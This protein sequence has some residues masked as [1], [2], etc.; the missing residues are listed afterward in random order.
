MGCEELSQAL[1]KL[2]LRDLESVHWNLSSAQLYEAAIRRREG[3][4]AYGGALVTRTGSFTGRAPNDKFIVDEPGSRDKIWW[5]K[6]NRPFAEDRFDA[7]YRKACHFL[8]GETVFVQDC[9][10]NA[11]PAYETSV[12]VITQ[13]AW[14]SLF[15]RNLFIRPEDLNRAVEPGESRITVLHVPHLH[16]DPIRDGTN[17]EAF[18]L[19][20]FSRSLVLIGGTQYAG[21]IK[22]SVFSMMNYLLPQQGILSM[23]AAAN[24]G[25]NGD[26]T[27]FFG[28]SGT[29]KTTLSA[30]P[31]RQ[32][33]GDDETG[34]GENGLFN[35]EGGCYA[36]VINLSP[37]KEPLIF[38]TTRHFGTILENVG[39]DFRHRQV[40]LYDASLTE[41][42]RA[43][44]PI[45]HIP[46]AIYPGLSNHP[47]TLVMLTCDAFGVLPPI[48]HL[49]CA[50]A[51]Y[52]FLSGYTAKVAGTEAGIT[53]PQTTFSTC[54]GAPFMSLHPAVYAKLLGERIKSCEVNCWLLN[55]GW[56]GGPYGIGSRMDIQ[57]TRRLLSA[58]LN[59][60]LDHVAYHEDPVFG[61]QVPESCPGVPDRLLNTIDTWDDPAAYRDKAMELA[62][63][64]HD[65][66]QAFREMAP[67]EV[68]EAGPRLAP[69]V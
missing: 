27:V 42:T 14:H 52:H 47:R 55:T 62:R 64:F 45:T 16:A 7:L 56:T 38:E 46:N 5:G 1:A 26:S 59:G 60:E 33:V 24:V 21:E 18:I 4:L 51:M 12:R 6:V 63:A 25:K 54:F 2:G 65:N 31:E 19:L 10:V 68:V 66:F 44:Y 58:A 8:Q 3:H 36:K 49:N 50:Q 32:L 9:L 23:H 20:H 48:A 30:D 43:A 35:L 15:A 22:K 13:D 67:P 34:W 37:E 17:S 11:D 69:S 57:V 28:L 53:E 39:L 41:N 61:F 29:G 40:D